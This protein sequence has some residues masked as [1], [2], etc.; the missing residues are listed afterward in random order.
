MAEI[1]PLR[2]RMIDDMM[3]RNLSPT[4]QQSYLYAVTK[5]SRHFSCSPDRLGLEEVRA[6]QLHLIAQRRS[7]S[8]INQTVC[9]LRFFYG[10]TLGR[11]DALERIVAAREPQKLPVVLSADEIVLFLEAVSGLRN[12]AA[13]TTAYGAGLRVG[14]VARLTIGAIDSRRMLIRVEQGKGGKD[15]YVMLSPQLLQILRAYWRLARP[16]RWLFPGRRGGRAGQRRHTARGLP[17]GGAARRTQQAGDGAHLAAQLRHP[18]ARSRHR[19]PDHPGAAR[20][21]PA[22]DDRPL[23]SGRDNTDRRYDQPARSPQLG[24][25]AAELIVQRAF[26]ARGGGHL[27]SPRR[28]L[29]RRSAR[30]HDPRT[31]PRHGGDR[32]LPDGGARRPCRTL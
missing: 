22:V 6:Y 24:S 28:C 30:Q 5:F 13:L 26:R 17:G 18:P 12:R 19:Y 11:T 29:S 1:S 8:H 31:T 15:R 21:C 23:Y 7:W 16:S 20:P 4:T 9:A 25:D 10:V 27:P 14:E 3:I 32:G 2:R